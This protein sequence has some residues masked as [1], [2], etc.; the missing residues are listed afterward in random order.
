MTTNESGYNTNTRGSAGTAYAPTYIYIEGF[1]ARVEP[2]L[3]DG[4]ETPFHRKDQ[5]CFLIF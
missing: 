4:T 2:K 1:V 5:S 3:M